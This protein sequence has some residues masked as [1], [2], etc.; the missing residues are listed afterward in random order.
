MEQD[1]GSH[2][3]E[4]VPPSLLGNSPSSTLHEGRGLPSS[5]GFGVGWTLRK[6]WGP[7]ITLGSYLET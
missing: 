7:L 4:V 1:K 3:N 6:S 2:A 5:S